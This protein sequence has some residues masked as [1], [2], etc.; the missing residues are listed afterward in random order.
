[1]SD[2]CIEDCGNFLCETMLYCTAVLC[3]NRNVFSKNSRMVSVGSVLHRMVSLYS[4][5][6]HDVIKQICLYTVLSCLRR[7]VYSTFIRNSL[8]MCPTATIKEYSG[9]IVMREAAPQILSTSSCPPHWW[10]TGD[11]PAM[12]TC[13]YTSAVVTGEGSGRRWKAGWEAFIGFY[14]FQYYFSGEKP[15]SAWHVKCKLVLWKKAV[16]K[17]YCTP[18]VPSQNPMKL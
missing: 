2:F 12:Y 15:W 4:S 3:V 18:Q 11:W 9:L 7:Q 6:L 16:Y 10:L 5:E 14:I 17:K 1:M 8:K 13:R